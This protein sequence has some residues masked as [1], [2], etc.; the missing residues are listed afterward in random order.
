M[1]AAALSP[2]GGS[3]F[4]RESRQEGLSQ[5]GDMLR[6]DHHGWVGFCRWPVRGGRGQHLPQ[7]Q[8][9]AGS[10]S[11]SLSLAPFSGPA[12]GEGPVLEDPQTGAL[13]YIGNKVQTI[14]SCIGRLSRDKFGKQKN[15]RTLQTISRHLTTDWLLAARTAR[16][17]RRA[18]WTE[19]LL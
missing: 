9:C 13:G 19:G 14:F 2:A 18:A 5:P 17:Q 10:L 4:A 8:A 7:Q 15:I 3:L 6:E 16:P 1:T 11:P 12:H